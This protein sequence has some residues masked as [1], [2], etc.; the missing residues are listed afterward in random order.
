M[1]NKVCL[2]PYYKVIVSHLHN[3]P[4]TLGFTKLE[5][6]F[7]K[8]C[9]SFASS[10]MLECNNGGH[11][12]EPARLE[13]EKGLTPSCLLPIGVRSVAIAESSPQA[14]LLHSA[15]AVN[16]HSSE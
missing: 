7:C 11:W 9:F 1:H 12:W 13:E 6:G 4:Y 14:I 10:S 16:S 5:M 15:E 3:H 2:P 8:P